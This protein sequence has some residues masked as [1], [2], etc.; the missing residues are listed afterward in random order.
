MVAMIKLVSGLQ[1]I[2]HRWSPSMEK[3]NEIILIP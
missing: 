2:K 3:S 1:D